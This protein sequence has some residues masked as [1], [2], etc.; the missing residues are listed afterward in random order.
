L[1]FTTPLPKKAVQ[2]FQEN[3]RGRDFAV[4]D[5]HGMFS[6]LDGLLE[7]VQFDPELDRL[8]SVGDLI[9]RGPESYRALEFLA[10]P[11]FH[12][13]QGNHE[14]IMLDAIQEGGDMDTWLHINGG[15]WWNK[16]S[17]DL[18][19]QFIETISE[20]PIAIE[21]QMPK[22]RVGIIHADIAHG[23]SWPEFTATLGDDAKAVNY[24][25][26][27]RNRLRMTELSGEPA[28]VDGVDLMIVGHTPL[29]N[30]VLIGNIYYLDTAAAYSSHYEDAKLSM[31]QFSPG[32]ELTELP[33]TALMSLGL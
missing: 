13:V 20:L 14:R 17:E 1:S 3:I 22:A 9:D 27:S 6:S 30:A 26:W 4:G 21:I 32:L 2:I 7:A 10:Q 29:K 12:A 28:P 16:I 15:S 25:V 19:R 5:L 33:T 8:F 24:A 31:L 11:W 23:M 18:R